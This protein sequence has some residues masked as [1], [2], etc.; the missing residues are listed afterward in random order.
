MENG[1]WDWPIE[2]RNYIER[3]KVVEVASGR[4]NGK[5]SPPDV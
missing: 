3:S 1:G 4:L 2:K 5:I